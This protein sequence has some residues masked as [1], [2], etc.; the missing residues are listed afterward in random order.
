MLARLAW[1]SV[2]L[3]LASPA[4]ADWPPFGRAIE[5]AGDSQ[6]H[7]AIATDG[8][9]GA[10]VVWQDP[11]FERENIFV[12]HVLASGDLDPTWPVDGRS[13]LGDPT[14]LDKA[15]GGQFF[16]VIVSD[17]AHGAIVA[18]QDLR[19]SLTD[20]D[21]FAQHI[22]AS[23]VVDPAWPANGTA[24]TRELGNQEELRIVSDG[25]GGAIVS[26]I[27]ARKGVGD[28]D[29]FAQHVL[30]TGVV[31]LRWPP[32]GLGV[33]L[34]PGRQQFQDMTSD[35]LGGAILAWDDN[36]AGALGFDVFAEHVLSS[37]ADDPAWPANGRAVCTVTGDQGRVTITSD[38]A[39]GAIVGWSDG[40]VLGTDH[41]FA[42]H[43][44]ATGALDPAWPVNGTAVSN[45]GVLESRPLAVPDGTGGAIINW[46]AFTTH[47]DMFVQHV[48]A[49]GLLD[50]LWP[51]AG[52]ALTHTLRQQT[53]A[54]IVPD[55]AGGAVIAWED[56]G[57][58]AAQHVLASGLLDPAY[59][60]TF[61]EVCNLPSQQGDPALVATS[62]GGAI[63]SWTDTRN[64]VDTDIF[65]MQILEAGTV[66]APPVTPALLAFAPLSPNPARGLITLRFSLPRAARANLAIYDVEGR[67]VR[68]LASGVRAPGQ[69]SVPWDGRDDNGRPVHAGVYFARLE[70]E[71][72]AVTAKLAT[73]P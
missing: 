1:V 63:V 27:D 72:R 14:A 9:D 48:K 37:G 64:A 51:A 20:F 6:V 16:P 4:A 67:R 47:L 65:A 22:L 56:S 34:L 73:L 26:W 43:V 58:V 46:M 24:L 11:R 33:C 71:G 62:G 21:V 31:D 28:P 42:E 61:R 17:G 2:L 54:E 55:G 59:P 15:D 18:W 69:Q 60:D 10:I 7:S 50:P 32:D 5:T 19:D 70:A 23:G 45:A 39:H 66:D 25:A 13:L 29:V 40:R 12:Q 68:Q 49:N 36:R 35:G 38:G 30:S 52:K 41:I 8:S 57:D 44:L 3:A 53:N